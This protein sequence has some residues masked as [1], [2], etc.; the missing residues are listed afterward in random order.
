MHLRTFSLERGERRTKKYPRYVFLS[1]T[2]KMKIFCLAALLAAALLA[3]SSTHAAAVASELYDDIV[4]DYGAIKTNPFKANIEEPT[5]LSVVG[6]VSGLTVL[7]LA[8]G[9]G[10]FTRKLLAGGAAAVTGVDV[11]SGMI[12]EAR[13][14]DPPG[15]RSSTYRVATAGEYAHP[16]PVDLVTAQYLL[17]YADAKEEL[18]E[19]CHSFY[20]NAGDGGRFVSMSSVRESNGRPA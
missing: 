16:E 20:R 7:D 6:A 9:S 12:D 13:R 4:F 3:T 11:S 17:D 19:L 10:H 15:S 8:C 5:F 18:H 2:M 14:I 1:M